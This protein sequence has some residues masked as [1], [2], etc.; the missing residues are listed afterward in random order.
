M[1][2]RIRKRSAKKDKEIV[3]NQT[4]SYEKGGVKL[5]FTL[6]NKNLD[7]AIIFMELLD[8]GIQDVNK[9]I[10]DIKKDLGMDH[11]DKED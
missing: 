6:V 1:F 11:K 7:E 5:N 9:F 10:A 8:R 3:A 4:F 2:N